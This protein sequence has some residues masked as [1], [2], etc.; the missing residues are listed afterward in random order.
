MYTL[1]QAKEILWSSLRRKASTSLL[2]ISS[3]Y[4]RGGK[5]IITYEN[6]SATCN[7]ILWNLLNYKEPE[8]M[9]VLLKKKHS[10]N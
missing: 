4:S 7:S 5:P 8:Y 3:Y 9:S 6:R 1:W 2:L 10:F